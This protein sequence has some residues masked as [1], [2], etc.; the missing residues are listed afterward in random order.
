M[1]DL[2]LFEASVLQLLLF[3]L[4]GE[5]DVS[6]LAGSG[7]KEDVLGEQRR[8]KVSQRST[9]FFFTFGL[10]ISSIESPFVSGSMKPKMARTTLQPANI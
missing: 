2:A 3:V 9:C 6:G 8:S 10:T 1:L 7:A 5:V 4:S